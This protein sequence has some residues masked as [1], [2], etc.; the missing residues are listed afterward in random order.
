[1][2]EV[3]VALAT[4]KGEK[5]VWA[6]VSTVATAIVGVLL[7]AF[8]NY[9]FAQFKQLQEDVARRLKESQD[10][11]TLLLEHVQKTETRH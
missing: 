1:M 9:K 8:L 7:A 3:I 4:R 10:H 11:N 2:E 6:K 5:A